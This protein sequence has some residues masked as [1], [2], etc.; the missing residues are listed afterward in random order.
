[1]NEIPE[2]FCQCGCGQRTKITTRTDSGKNYVKGEYLRVLQGHHGR[3]PEE[4]AQYFWKRVDKSPHPKGCWLW[5]G[6]KNR[7]G[8]G[9]TMFRK[10]HLRA[11][12]VAYELANGPIPEGLMVLHSC[13]NPPCVNPDHLFL[14]TGT[15]NMQ[16]CIRKG[17]TRHDRARQ[18]KP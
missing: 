14:G 15:D 2:G 3:T 6:S 18:A 13:D 9:E 4:F 16:D 8:Y 10:R 17:R 5:T 12:R 7:Q 11:N 1:M